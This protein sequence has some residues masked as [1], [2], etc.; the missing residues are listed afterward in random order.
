MARWP[1]KPNKDVEPEE[2][3]IVDKVEIVDDYNFPIHMYR[4]KDGILE[5]KTIDRVEDSVGWYLNKYDAGV[6]KD[7][8]KK[9]EFFRNMESLI[10]DS[11]QNLASKAREKIT[12]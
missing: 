2:A 3:N 8:E 11:N 6:P 1:K 10:P 4:V 5:G 9:Q 7:P 12:S